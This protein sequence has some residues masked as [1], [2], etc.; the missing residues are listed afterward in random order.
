VLRRVPVGVHL[1]GVPLNRQ[2]PGRAWF[3]FDC[4]NQAIIA[5]PTRHQTF[6]KILDRLVMHGIHGCLSNIERARGTASRLKPYRVR[7]GIPSILGAVVHL[8][9][10]LGGKV[11]KKSTSKRDIDELNSSTDA[12]DRE[13]SLPGYCKER[14]LEQIPFPAGLIQKGRRIRAIP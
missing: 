14:Q 12:Q 11:L 7:A 6:S 10:P 8:A 3:A 9:R 5:P 13:P 1:F 4:F 2:N